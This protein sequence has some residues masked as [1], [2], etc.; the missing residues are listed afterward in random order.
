M[1]LDLT[2]ANCKSRLRVPE[3]VSSSWYTCP[4]CLARVDTELYPGTTA[5]TAIPVPPTD[6]GITARVPHRPASEGGPFAD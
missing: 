4:R 3:G 6:A 1:P 5:L 2:C